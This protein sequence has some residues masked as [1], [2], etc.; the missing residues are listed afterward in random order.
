MSG[1][2]GSRGSSRYRRSKSKPNGGVPSDLESTK[3]E[4]FESAFNTIMVKHVAGVPVTSFD[5]K[6]IDS[7]LDTVRSSY[8][9]EKF[10][11]ALASS[12]CKYNCLISLMVINI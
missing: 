4:D 9:H 2:A 5:Q 8:V 7:D 12:P 10:K 3:T 1:G 6:N 11:E